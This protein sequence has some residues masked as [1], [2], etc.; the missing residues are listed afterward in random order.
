VPLKDDLI[1]RT[2]EQLAQ[3]V[4]ALLGLQATVT[5]A[6]A[7]R[8]IAAAYEQHTG[9]SALLLR[10]LSAAQLLP[11]ISSAGS[12]DREKAYLLAGLAEAEGAVAAAQ[13]QGD[14]DAYRL[15]ALELYLE[16]GLAGLALPEVAAAVRRVRA[17]L[18]D[19][20]LSEALAWRLLAFLEASG[21]YAEAENQLFGLLERLGPTDDLM[22]RGRSFYDR[23]LTLPDG[24]LGAGDLPRDEVLEGREALEAAARSG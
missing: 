6:E 23:L 7:E 17:D 18:P 13:Q 19:E 15:K 22:A 4:R 12:L 9:G 3:V 2:L 14:A 16:T 21:D 10:R 24:A 20:A 5:P 11:I 8:I 1:Q